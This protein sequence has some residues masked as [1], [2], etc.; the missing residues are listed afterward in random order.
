MTKIIVLIEDCHGKKYFLC[1]KLEPEKGNEKSLP[2]K[3][4][5]YSHAD[6]GKVPIDFL[7]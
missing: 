7:T 5:L 1:H 2:K 6:V 3:S 4:G